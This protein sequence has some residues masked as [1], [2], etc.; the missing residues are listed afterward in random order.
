VWPL[1]VEVVD[2]DAED[3]LELAA[4]EDQEPIEALS[5]HAADPALCVGV[6]VRGADR[7][8][9]DRDVFALE[10][11]VEGAADFVSRS[12]IRKRGRRPRSSR[13]ISRL[14]ACCA[15]QAALGLLVQA[16]YSTLRVPIETKKSTYNRRSRTVSTVKKPQASTVSACWRRNE[17]RLSWS[18]RGAGGMPARGS[19]FR[20]GVAETVIPSLRQLAD[21]PNIAPVAVL[22]REPQN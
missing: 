19:T 3:M 17:R 1:L 10:D 11:A 18:R 12:W 6:R 5:T 21:D 15:I 2:V 13:S 4:T 14:R 22:A 16:R 7:C 9:D 8:A 20:T